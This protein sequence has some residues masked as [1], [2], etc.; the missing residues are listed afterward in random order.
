MKLRLS[1]LVV[2]ISCGTAT[3]A[4]GERPVDIPER[5][6]GAQRVVVA[7]ATSV[8]TGWR[9]NGFGDHL[10][11]SEV[12]LA[13]EETLKGTP[14][15]VLKLDL[16]GGTLDG[17]TLRVSSVAPLSPGERAVFFLD[18]TVLGAHVP[19][20]KGQGILKL[21]SSN[22]VTGSSLRL[23]DVRRMVKSSGR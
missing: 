21:D 14:A 15:S 20:L 8:T 17:V 12:S 13:V 1:W 9:H 18:S 23:D 16:E 7:K 4:T 5:A 11:V 2:L 19:H 22:Q 10:I 6:R 3:V